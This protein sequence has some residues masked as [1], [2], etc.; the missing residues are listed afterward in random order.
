MCNIGR[1]AVTALSCYMVARSI[2]TYYSTSRRTQE[3]NMLVGLSCGVVDSVSPRLILH[4][5]T[6]DRG[7]TISANIGRAPFTHAPCI[8]HTH[9][10]RYNNIVTQHTTSHTSRIRVR[11][12]HVRLR[13]SQSLTH[14]L[15]HDIVGYVLF[16]CISSCSRRRIVRELRPKPGHG[17]ANE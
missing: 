3:A 7:R 4:H 15:A 10:L 11:K 8:S 16:V 9:V 13:A 17:N 5:L 14:R 2:H 12:T 6:S 1:I